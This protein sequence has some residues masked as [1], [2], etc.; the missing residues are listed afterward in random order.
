MSKDVKIGGGVMQGINQGNLGEVKPGSFAPMSTGLEQN[1]IDAYGS[2][3]TALKAS[4]STAFASQYQSNGAY[5]YG[6]GGDAGSDTE[7]NN[8]GNNGAMINA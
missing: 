7:V 3:V 4:F 8:S 1:P 5:A 2:D 6:E